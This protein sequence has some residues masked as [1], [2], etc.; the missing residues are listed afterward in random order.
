MTSLF[1]GLHAQ[2]HELLATR[3][4]QPLGLGAGLVGYPAGLA[5]RLSQQLLRLLLS[6]SPQ[7]LELGRGLRARPLGLL[8]RL[9]PHAPGLA[10]RG[11][12]QL[13]GLLA[14]AGEQRV[15]L[16]MGL[17]KH[18]RRLVA[19]ALG[20]GMEAGHGR[21]RLVARGLGLG[22]RRAHD[23][24][25]LLLGGAYAILR[26]PVRLRDPLAGATLGLPAKLRRGPF[27]RRDDARTIRRQHQPVERSR[28][29]VPLSIRIAAPA[30]VARGGWQ[31]VWET[32]PCG[33]IARA[34]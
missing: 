1:V 14:R 3:G 32:C 11:R 21:E 24:L 31:K 10:L 5:V 29:F 34:P 28:R 27:G 4:Q 8:R 23:L 18:S 25:G 20:L 13:L 16:L 12:S 7:S 15:G 6:G 22:A 2:P 26:R 30:A 9:R 17:G 19:H 33:Q